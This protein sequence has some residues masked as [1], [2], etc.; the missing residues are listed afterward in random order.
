MA[1]EG[2]GRLALTITPKGMTAD[3]GY[4]FALV[5][6]DGSSMYSTAYT[7]AF[8]A[9]PPVAIGIAADELLAGKGNV[10]VGS[11]VQMIAV[12]VPTDTNL[13]G[14]TWKSSNTDVATVDANG[15]VIA[16]NNG[17][18]IITVTST[19]VPTVSK[20]ITVTVSD[21]VITLN[22]DELVSQGDAE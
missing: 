20:S 16:R 14:V 18:A 9:I 17:T 12:L 10:S 4:A 21:G 8:Y 13:K 19:S 6:N 22:T 2:N 3:R 5:M 11:T 7:S 1:N 15:M